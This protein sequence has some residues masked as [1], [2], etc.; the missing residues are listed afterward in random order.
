[1]TDDLVLVTGGEWVHRAILHAGASWCWLSGENHPPVDVAQAGSARQSGRPAV[2]NQATACRFIQADLMSDAGWPEAV[3]GCRYVIHGASPTPSGD[4]VREEDWVKARGRGQPARLRAARDAG[5]KRVV[6]TS[7]FGAIAG[8]VLSHG[9]APST[10]PTGA[11]W[12]ATSRR[13]RSRRRSPSARRGTLSP[14][15]ETVLSLQPSIRQPYWGRHSAP[16]I[17]IQSG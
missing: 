4:Q 10:R 2:L 13:T 14:G 16:T 1:M 11:I 9:A 15:T 8:G 5:V 6:L 12:P 3:S 17:H 7:A